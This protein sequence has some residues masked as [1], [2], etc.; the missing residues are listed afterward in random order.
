MVQKAVT[1]S[2]IGSYRFV[3][4]NYGLEFLISETGSY[5]SVHIRQIVTIFIY[6]VMKTS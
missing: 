6:R 1:S 5:T 2:N 4:D 3:P